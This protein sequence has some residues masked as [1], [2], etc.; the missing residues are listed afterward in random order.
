[1]AQKN[2]AGRLPYSLTATPESGHSTGSNVDIL[3]TAQ[4][5]Q[6]DYQ[7]R[8]IGEYSDTVILTV[9]P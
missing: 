4:V 1:M 9:E 6:A 3:L 7:N 8:P 2:G 5:R